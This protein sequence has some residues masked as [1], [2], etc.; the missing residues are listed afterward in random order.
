MT[1]S[2][3]APKPGMHRVYNLEVETDHHF[4]VT[5]LGVLTQRPIVHLGTGEHSR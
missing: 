5:K 4:F 2:T 1:I 3:I